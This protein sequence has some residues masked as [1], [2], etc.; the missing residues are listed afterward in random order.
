MERFVHVAR[1][2]E[3]VRGAGKLVLVEGLFIALL[4]Y[5]G[6]FYALGDRCPF[7]GRSVSAGVVTGSFVE[8]LG[9]RAKFY[10]P[11][12]ECLS[13]PDGEHLNS[14]RVRVDG[15]GIY[16]DLGGNVALEKSDEWIGSD[17]HA[18]TGTDHAVL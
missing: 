1:V 4:N 5:D 3:L 10:I 18:G 2:D 15:A 7:D 12:G 9:D 6:A 14:Y 13:Q 8:C 17:I 11:T 16:V